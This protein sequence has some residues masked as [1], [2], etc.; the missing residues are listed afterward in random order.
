MIQNGSLGNAVV[1][2]Q[3]GVI[4]PKPYPSKGLVFTHK[5]L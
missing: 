2:Q 5:E 1:Q 3:I 4:G